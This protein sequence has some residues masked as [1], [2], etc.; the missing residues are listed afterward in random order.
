MLTALFCFY[1]ISMSKKSFLILTVSFVIVKLLIHFLTSTNYELHRDEMLYFSMGSHQSW[2]FASTPP[3]MAFISFIVK[4]L[5]GY[6]EFFVK[7]FPALAGASIILLIALFV[8]E[9]GGKG[10][11]VFTACLAGIISTSLLRSSSL[12]MP[13]IFELLLWTLFLYFLLKLI[14]RQDPRYWIH[15]GICFGL[16]F[17]NKYSILFLGLATLIAILATTNRKLLLSKYLIYAAVAAIM[18]MLPNIIWQVVHKFPVAT[19]MGELYR[20]QLNYVSKQTFLGEQIMMNFTAILIWL[21][22]ISVLI[23]AKKEK[24]YRLFAWSFLLVIVLFLVTKGKPYYTLGV[25]P[26]LFAFGGYYLEKYLPG[27]LRIISF[28]IIGYSFFTSLLF[29]PLGLPL[30]PQ[31]QMETYCSFFSKHISPAPMRNEQNQYYPLPQDYMDMTGWKELASLASIAYNSLDSLQQRDCIIYANNYGQAGALDFYGKKYHLPPP[32][33]VNDSY[34][35][36]AP[37]SLVANNFIVSDNNPGDIPRLF[38]TYQEIGEIKNPYFRENG[39]KVFLCQNPTPLLN[40]FF[41]K[42]IRANKEI[43]GY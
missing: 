24:K 13:V 32:V 23:F 20:T 4:N 18:I 41:K 34:I 17:L 7:L 35:F 12:F 11:A 40:E 38:K 43:Y 8:R 28:M 39:L 16:A 29:I 9:L 42:R 3:M 22:G 6:H 10:F 37:D 2:G 33:S 30:L 27:R 15:L 25:Y 26:M 19:H 36:W 31:K 21:T 1:L 5:F 14:N